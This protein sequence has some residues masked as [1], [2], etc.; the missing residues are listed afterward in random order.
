[1]PQ[2]KCRSCNQSVLLEDKIPRGGTVQCPHCSSGVISSKDID[3]Y[4]DPHKGERFVAP[5]KQKRSPFV[6]APIQGR[7]PGAPV[8]T[9]WPGMNLN[10]RVTHVQSLQSATWINAGDDKIRLVYNCLDPL[11][12]VKEGILIDCA[13][14]VG[15]PNV[16][17]HFVAVAIKLESPS[18]PTEVTEA[19]GEAAA[20]FCMLSA[21]RIGNLTLAGFDMHWGFHLHAGAG[22]DQIWKRTTINGSNQYLIVEA[23]GPNQF[24][25]DNIWMPPQ[26]EQMSIR[27][28]MHNLETMRRN[29]HQIATDIINDLNVTMGTRW[30]HFNN[31]SKNYYGVTG[32]TA[33]PVADLYGVVIKAV[34]RPDGMLHYSCSGFNE[35]RNLTR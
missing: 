3:H 18:H 9:D 7:S 11:R 30:P 21:T 26:F 25:N 22:I 5:K 19:T 31:S 27:W 14:K 28:I 6:A 23:K 1:M 20:A 32:T 12:P 10:T 8:R 16:L 33:A 34:W 35:Y 24:L 17:A 13:A 2:Y 15:R 4:W 29:G